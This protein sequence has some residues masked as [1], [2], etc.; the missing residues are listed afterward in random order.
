MRLH[1]EATVILRHS[2]FQVCYLN[3]SAVIAMVN[4]RAYVSY[5]AEM[6]GR[7]NG[8]CH[9]WPSHVHTNH[10]AYVNHLFI[11]LFWSRDESQG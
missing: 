6:V 10:I 4:V 1:E 7:C 5:K 8:G 11:P 3:A 2:G 9:G